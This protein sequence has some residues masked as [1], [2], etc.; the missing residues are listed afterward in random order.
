MFQVLN[1]GECFCFPIYMFVRPKYEWKGR[2]PF[3]DFVNR[4]IHNK[5]CFGIGPIVKI[6]A[7]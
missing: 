6:I 7:V 3:L 4:N 2:I 5:Q 1:N